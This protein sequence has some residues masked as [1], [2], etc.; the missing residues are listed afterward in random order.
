MP[1]KILIDTDPGIDDAMA[2]FYAL[3]SPELEVVGLTTIFGNVHT[4]L[5][6]RN[7]LTLLE[8]A[9]RVDIRVAQ[10]AVAPLAMAFEGP[11]DFVHGDDG[12]G[13]V[14]LPAPAATPLD[15]DAA[16]YIVDT[17]MAAPSEVTLVALGPLT[18]VAVALK[19]EPRLAANLAEI[20]LMGGSAFLPGNATPAAEANIGNDPEAADIVFGATCPVTMVG[21]DVTH[22]ILMTTDDL[23][24]IDGFSSPQAQHIAKI[25]PFYEAFYRSVGVDGGIYIHDSTTITYLLAPHLFESVEHP[26]RVDTGNSVARGET[27][28]STWEHGHQA[29]W[30]DRPRIRILTQVDGRAAVELELARLAGD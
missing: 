16:Q 6:T 23:R 28:V 5:A 10:G 4:E 12:Q 14:H 1:R 21:L 13:N 8:I 9:G 27:V 18:N 25:L 22:Q 3:E 2:I 24:R 26:V 30:A 29:P 19:I 17:A 11:A 15:I 20:V 7:A